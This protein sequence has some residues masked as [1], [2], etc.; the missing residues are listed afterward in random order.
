MTR[1]EILAAMAALEREIDGVESRIW[2]E[3][4]KS[5]RWPEVQAET[6]A[7]ISEESNWLSS[8]EERYEELRGQL[9]RQ[10]ALPAPPAN[11]SRSALARRMGWE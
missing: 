10:P 9:R 5:S 8:L 3:G 1:N 11:A 2:S 6:D 7:K 4:G